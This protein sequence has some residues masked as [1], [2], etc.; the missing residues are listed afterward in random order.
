MRKVLLTGLVL[1]GGVQ[2]GGWGLEL[3]QTSIATKN[4][5]VQSWLLWMSV[6]TKKKS[7]F[8]RMCDC[9]VN[10][11][12]WVVAKGLRFISKAVLN[13]DSEFYESPKFSLV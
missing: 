4:A 3:K 9:K 8:Q 2:Q 10:R 12:L 6:E 7:K 5:S 11:K 1:G 13:L